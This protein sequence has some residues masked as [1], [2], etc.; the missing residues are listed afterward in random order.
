MA[1]RGRIVNRTW[2]AD[3]EQLPS[4][5]SPASFQDGTVAQV[6]AAVAAL[7]A[8]QEAASAAA[9]AA[10]GTPTASAEKH[11]PALTVA[12]G[13]ATAT[14]N[15]SM[16]EDHWIQYLWAKDQDG[17]VVAVKKLDPAEQPVLKFDV[18]K[19]ATSLTAFEFCNKYVGER[20]GGG[21]SQ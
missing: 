13:K 9:A 21:G 18:P 12:N 17:K 5:H 11:A 3:E 1:Q 19:G 15:H 8:A 14:V 2:G 7:E 6:K 4:R 10:A 20:S 16:A